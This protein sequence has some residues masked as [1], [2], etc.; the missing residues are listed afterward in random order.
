[1]QSMV[2][3]AE[4]EEEG[5]DTRRWRWPAVARTDGGFRSCAV[6]WSPF[7][8][9]DVLPLKV[10]EVVL[11]GIVSSHLLCHLLMAKIS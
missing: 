8:Q 10:K 7:P 11:H 1:M 6:C 2:A 3:G 4:R 5:A 9:F